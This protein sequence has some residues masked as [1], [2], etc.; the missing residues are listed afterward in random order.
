MIIVND[1]QIT[2]IWLLLLITE[3]FSGKEVVSW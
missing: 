1:I 2:G 3:T